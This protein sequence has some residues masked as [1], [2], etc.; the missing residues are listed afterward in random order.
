M[1][2]DLDKSAARRIALGMARMISSH[3]AECRICARGGR[4]TVGRGGMRRERCEAERRLFGLL[5]AA[6][7]EGWPE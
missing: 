6:Q 4:I 3:H 2:S 7:L 5:A 1:L